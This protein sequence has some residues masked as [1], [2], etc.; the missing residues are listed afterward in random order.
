MEGFR[1][2]VSERLGVGPD[3]CLERNPRLIYGRITGYGQDG[4]LA[5]R[6]GHDLNYTAL[7]RVIDLTAPADGPPVIPPNLISA[8]AAARLLIAFGILAA[9]HEPPPPAK[10][11]PVAPLGSP[12]A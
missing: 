8:F 1:P 10:R 6:A 2:G 9:P 4:P 5:Q 3:V 12:P 11:P 7:A